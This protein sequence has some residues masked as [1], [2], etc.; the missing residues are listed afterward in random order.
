[1]TDE[2]V[3]NS[4]ITYAS[5]LLG[6]LKP[7]T[8]SALHQKPNKF[9]KKLKRHVRFR[10]W[11]IRDQVQDALEN[12]SEDK[13]WSV[14]A[15]G[16][17]HT[18]SLSANIEGLPLRLYV[19]RTEDLAPIYDIAITLD[20]HYGLIYSEHDVEDEEGADSNAHRFYTEEGRKKVEREAVKTVLHWLTLLDPSLN[21]RASSFNQQRGFFRLAARYGFF[22]V[23]DLI[24][25]IYIAPGVVFHPNTQCLKFLTWLYRRFGY[26]EILVTNLIF[27]IARTPWLLEKLSA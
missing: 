24:F 11:D 18:Y 19:D 22:R 15:F 8:Y 14:V 17:D 2:I 21:Y 27:L 5:G 1:M 26:S 20:G 13:L 7:M 23:D 3:Y 16:Q 4:V 10:L 6:F 12:F 25:R 9:F